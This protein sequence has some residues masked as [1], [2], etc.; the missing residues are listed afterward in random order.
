LFVAFLGLVLLRNN[1][2]LLVGID[3][4]LLVALFAGGRRWLA[5]ATAAALAVYFALTYALFPNVGIKPGP[6]D[7][8]LGPAYHDIAVV[9]HD[10]PGSFTDRQVTLMKKVGTSKK[11]WDSAGADCWNADRLTLATRWIDRSAQRHSRQLFGLWRRTL[12][13]HPLTVIRA[14]LCRATIAWSPWRGSPALGASVFPNLDIPGNLFGW[15]PSKL[16]GDPEIHRAFQPDP[17][18]PGLRTAAR[19]Y[20][21]TSMGVGGEWIVWRGA[22]WC[23]LAYLAVA[24]VAIRRRQWIWVTIAG[25]A[26]ANQL[27]VLLDNPGQLIRYMEGCIYLG[28]LALPLLT[29][30]GRDRSEPSG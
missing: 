13:T 30:P 28:V 20:V 15:W 5:A 16:A 11:L 6:A 12:Q 27:T 7:L 26:L 25:A 18:I 14:R 3:G 21:S 23:Y 1:G 8:V 19:S 24:V 2:F 29:L 9:Y 4:A 17:P 22:T 10:D